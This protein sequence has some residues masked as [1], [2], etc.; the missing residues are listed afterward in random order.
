[1][2]ALACAQQTL[3]LRDADI[4]SLIEL[5]SAATGKNFVVD[6][7]VKA[8]VTVVSS[9]PMDADALYQTF[10]SILQVHE[11]AAVPSGNV[12][13]IVPILTG[14][15]QGPQAASPPHGPVA[16]DDLVTQVIALEHVPVMQ[17]E[18]VLRPLLPK[19]AVLTAYEPSNMLV[20]SDRSANLL[21]VLD[22]VRRLDVSKQDV[23][24]V[25]PLRNARADEVVQSLNTL[26]GEGV[27]Q[28][29]KVSVALSADTRTNS[30]L[31][32]GDAALR[33][34]MRAAI[35]KLD[36]DAGPA[37]EGAEVV[38]L[39]YAQ[40]KHLAEILKD[41]ASS[42]TKGGGKLASDSVSVLADE[43]TNS[44]VLSA[45]TAAATRLRA[46]IRLLDVPRYQ[47]QVEAIIAEVSEDVSRQ[48]GIE[49]SALGNRLLVFS[50][51]PSLL[52]LGVS[53]ASQAMSGGTAVDTSRA[54]GLSAAGS[55]VSGGTRFTALLRA[56]K[57][58]AHT[59]I[60]STPSIVTLDN[61][62]AEIAVGQ[63][64]PFLTGSY[65]ST[66]NAGGG[67]NAVNPF[68]T[69]ERKQV[70]LTLR[71]TPHIRDADA[72][73]LQLDI[74]QED[75]SL[76]GM[77]TSTDIITNQ[78]KLETS[79]VVRNDQVIALGGMR[80]QRDLRNASKVPVLGDVPLIGNLFRA[81]S[82]Q[83]TR[84]NLVVFV[85][86]FIARSPDELQQHSDERYGEVAKG[87][88]D[89]MDVLRAELG[90]QPAAVADRPKPRRF[91]MPSRLR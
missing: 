18:P 57:S 86:P 5:V 60:L 59:N 61:Q 90:P 75:S 23:I 31:L 54:E 10:L 58:D 44:L 78:R 80:T 89:A 28:D 87:A 9:Q 49:L 66:G 1:M 45:P 85:H 91:D 73:T 12:I 37:E 64:V 21:R 47:I 53:A 72:G 51:F 17:L 27:T 70:G 79:I 42:A 16:P 3:N 33:L 14:E 13:K 4:H 83:H 40:A 32:N 69:V 62:E 26:K 8:E 38:H 15:Q 25:V 52:K 74:Y 68:Q 19:E 7:R 22:I 20:L 43:T 34:Q 39:K 41:Y 6:P 35:L 50:D 67:N 82:N 11:F 65:A 77:S 81:S 30:V 56:L 88:T 48:L 36:E 2:A 24:E 76:A 29:K 63:E 84:M 46:I 55:V 71:V